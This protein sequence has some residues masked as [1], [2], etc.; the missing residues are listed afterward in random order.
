MSRHTLASPRVAVL[1]ATMAIA[2][3]APLGASSA[4]TDA[5]SLRKIAS[6]LDDRMG[7]I[8]IEA[9][10]PV[11]YVASQPDPR[12]FVVELRDVVVQGF[13]DDV[14]ADPRHPIAAVQVESAK[15][16]DGVDV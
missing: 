1:C 3:M 4:R 13:A 8:A 11:P 12:T 7:V 2:V 6:R 10:A 5:A 14:N 9:T 16:A 15:A